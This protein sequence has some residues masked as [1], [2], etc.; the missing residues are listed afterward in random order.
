M[1][2][3]GPTSV[4]ETTPVVDDGTVES[5]AVEA[6]LAGSGETDTPDASDGADSPDAK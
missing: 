4:A 1:S 2:A 3:D 6:E 5:P